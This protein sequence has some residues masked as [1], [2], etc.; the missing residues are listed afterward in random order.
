MIVMK[1]RL[2]LFTILFIAFAVI[3]LNSCVFE[4]TIETP[5]GD[6]IDLRLTFNAS[7]G[8]ATKAI[9]TDEEKFIG[10]VHVLS[11]YKD[12]SG[13]YRFGYNA[14]I[15]EIYDDNHNGYPA[16]IVW[17]KAKSYMQEQQFLVLVNAADELAAASP[18]PNESFDSAM[19][20]LTC[21]YR[22]GEWLPGSDDAIGLTP[23]KPFPMYAKTES[24]IVTSAHHGEIIPFAGA[25]YPLIRMVARID[26]SLHPNIDINNFVLRSA[27]FFNHQTAGY[28]S[29]EKSNF[30]EPTQAVTTAAVP[31]ATF[32]GGTPILQGV[33]RYSADYID[34]PRGKI[35]RTLYT[36]EAPA[37]TEADRLKGFAVVI[38]G[39]YNGDD[40]QLTYYRV[41]LKANNDFTTNLSSPILRNHLY[42]VQIK[43]VSGPGYPTEMEAYLGESKLVAEVVR[44]NQVDRN[45]IIPGEYYLNVDRDRFFFIAQN[46][47]SSYAGSG[48]IKVQTNYPSWTAE[49]YNSELP[50]A[51]SWIKNVT[52]T[53][54]KVT[55]DVD[56]NYSSFPRVNAIKVIAGNL[57]KTIYVAQGVNVDETIWPPNPMT[58]GVTPYV[59][60]FWRA[61][62]TGERVLRFTG[63]TYSGNGDPWAAYIHHYDPRWYPDKGDDIFLAA[64]NSPDPAIY[65]TNPGNAEDFPVESNWSFAQGEVNAS[66]PDIVLRIGLQRPFLAFKENDPDYNSSFPARYAVVYLFYGYLPDMRYIKIYL[67]QGEGP[68]FLMRYNDY[69]DLHGNRIDAQRISPY[70]LTAQELK[71]NPS[72]DFSNI[73]NHPQIPV[74]D[75]SANPPTGGGVFTDYP[76]QAGAFFQWAPQDGNRA[77]RAIHPVEPTSGFGANWTSPQQ[78]PFFTSTHEACPIGYRRPSDAIDNNSNE[79]TPWNAPTDIRGYWRSELRQSLFANADFTNWIP[80]PNPHNTLFGYYADGYFDRRAIVGPIGKVSA[81]SSLIAHSGTLFF[82]PGTNSGTNYASLFFPNSGHRIETDG[83]VWAEDGT[84]LTTYWSSTSATSPGDIFEGWG[85]HLSKF[86]RPDVGNF[87]RTSG[88]LVRCVVDPKPY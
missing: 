34:D 47:A 53:A 6:E 13:I 59:G 38:G 29:Y 33:I 25:P 55:F 71:N 20:R 49:A 8:P 18:F 64:G 7:S 17:I 22:S 43:S 50:G 69:V 74:R 36:Y 68:D 26:V 72:Y 39:F 56:Q 16:Q 46:N 37:Y 65:S 80:S 82:H 70:N 30:N 54:D 87:N 32:N 88:F 31:P 52:C 27:R 14:V 11:F 19:E 40:T 60:A 23:F 75:F 84:A 83:S 12:G 4:P 42:D 66:N 51:P 86:D 24:L 5:D 41:N 28:V 85:L 58:N 9:T 67:R 76:T 15:T 1:M 78:S 44:W 57:T 48:V 62:E 79:P 35:E 45:I 61:N 73:I 77:R 3:F 10:T 21:A 2:H 81:T 63:L